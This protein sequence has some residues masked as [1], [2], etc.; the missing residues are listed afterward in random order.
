[1]VATVFSEDRLADFSSACYNR[2]NDHHAERIIIGESRIMN[3]LTLTSTGQRPLKPLI[4]AALDNELRLLQAA[5]QRTE[6]RLRQFEA[7]N[8]MNSAE[9]L[10]RYENDE[11]P[12][13]LDYAEWIGEYRILTRLREKANAYREITFVH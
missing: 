8:G 2:N 4:E 9:F 11:L 6:G 1:M 5:I 3:Q 13:S 7:A 12:E 10:R